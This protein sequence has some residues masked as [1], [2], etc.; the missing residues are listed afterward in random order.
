MEFRSNVSPFISFSIHLSFVVRKT[1]EHI[2]RV[3]QPFKA[4]A[5]TVSC[6]VPLAKMGYANTWSGCFSF[7]DLFTT[8]RFSYFVP[9]CLCKH[10]KALAHIW[11][12]RTPWQFITPVSSLHAVFEQFQI[13]ASGARS[14][15]N[16][17]A[18]RVV[19]GI[20]SELVVEHFY[21]TLDNVFISTCMQN[22]WHH[23]FHCV[24][25]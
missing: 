3:A 12:L 6:F 1:N 9:S 5:A 16:A 23:T 24:Q 15:G 10:D 20:V 17:K 18:W 2:K 14:T 11:H 8:C 4:V 19:R 13:I 25:L 7:H 22:I 21:V